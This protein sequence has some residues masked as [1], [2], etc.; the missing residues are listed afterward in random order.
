MSQK[1]YMAMGLAGTLLLLAGCAEYK[2]DELD[3]MTFQGTDFQKTLARNYADLAHM[4]DRYDDDEDADYFADK[5]IQ[6]GRGMDVMPE[7]P[8][9]WSIGDSCM[10]DLTQSYQRLMNALQKGARND[11]PIAAGEAQVFYDCWVEEADEGW[12]SYHRHHLHQRMCRD[13]FMEKIG[14]VES[15]M[16]QEESPAF[17]VLFDLNSATIDAEGMRVIE[18]A[19][20]TSRTQKGFTVHVL[21][22]TD[23]IGRKGYNKSLSARRAEAVRQALIA[24]GV[25]VTQTKALGETPGKY[26]EPDNRRADILWVK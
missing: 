1:S 7:D 23:R 17:V 11:V 24:R 16:N 25:P 18:K 22:R 20:E 2:L 12:M 10:P 6:A 3:H 8:R 9:D 19:V 13:G 5:A 4:E 26:V 21:G 15:I 14:I